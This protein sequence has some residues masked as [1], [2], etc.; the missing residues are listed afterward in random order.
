MAMSN[1][2]YESIGTE[3]MKKIFTEAY[4]NCPTDSPERLLLIMLVC[5]L[6]MKNWPQL[7][8]DYIKTTTK[9]DFLW[10]MFFK[11]QHYLQFN[12]FGDETKKI[13]GPT[14]DCYIAVNNM[15][16]RIKSQLV[17]KIE[18]KKLIG[19]TLD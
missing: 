8:K 1:F 13:I 7:L 16:K 3:K 10:V 6:K 9:K 12:Y 11:C 2:I 18:S 5:D 15:N 19:K 17:G 14:A 4:N